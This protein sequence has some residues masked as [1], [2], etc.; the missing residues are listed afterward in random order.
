MQRGSLDFSIKEAVEDHPRGESAHDRGKLGNVG[1]P[2]KKESETHTEEKL[3]VLHPEVS[4]TAYEFRSQPDA[5]AKRG[6][7]EE[8][9]FARRES[10]G[11]NADRAGNGEATDDSKD[12]QAEDVIDD[13]GTQDDACFFGGFAAN[14][15]EHASGNTNAGGREDAADKQIDRKWIVWMKEFHDRH[16]ENHRKNDA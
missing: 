8:S 14:V 13:S 3:Q 12:D 9:G 10:D 2:R 16:T 1:Q 7:E 15:A 6:D 11:G 4:E 5:D